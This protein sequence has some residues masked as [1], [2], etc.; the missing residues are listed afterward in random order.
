[1]EDLPMYS[2]H[3]LHI[4]L[5]LLQ[6]YQDSS[7]TFYCGM[8]LTTLSQQTL[9]C[10]PL[11]LTSVSHDKGHHGDKHSTHRGSVVSAVWARDG[12]INRLL[13]SMVSW[14]HHT[15]PSSQA[16]K[17]AHEAPGIGKDSVYAKVS[18]LFLLPLFTH[19]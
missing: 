6:S 18:N 7:Y 10:S 19:S 3:F 17:A 12:D 15:S 9:L 14:N 13:R 4:M 8:Q 5:M 11:D 1:M 2:S 16:L